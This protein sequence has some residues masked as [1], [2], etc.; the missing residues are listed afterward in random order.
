M[1]NW[2]FNYEQYREENDLAQDDDSWWCK[3]VSIR[4]DALLETCDRLGITLKAHPVEDK[5][6]Y[7]PRRHTDRYHSEVIDIIRN[8]KVDTVE[9]LREMGR[10]KQ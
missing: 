3:W 1:N 9:K 6:C 2:T 7:H 4:V 5:I 8:Y 10:I